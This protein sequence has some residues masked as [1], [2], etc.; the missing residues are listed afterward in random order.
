MPEYKAPASR[1]TIKNSAKAFLMDWIS[2]NLDTSG[3]T[4]TPWDDADDCAA[5]TYE[6][7][8]EEGKSHTAAMR[9]AKERFY[10]ELKASLSAQLEGVFDG[11]E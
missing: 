2:E 10:D 11:L 5:R 8:I 1:I 7:C 6:D 9:Y 3:D 4:S